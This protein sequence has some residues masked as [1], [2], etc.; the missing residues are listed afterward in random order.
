MKAG[1]LGAGLVAGFLTDL[2]VTNRWTL[3]QRH[4]G[5]RCLFGSPVQGVGNGEST[6]NLDLDQCGLSR[7]DIT[8]G[9]AVSF[10]NMLPACS[11]Q[12]RRSSLLQCGFP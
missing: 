2:A 4:S 5:P 8:F 6:M 1:V 7:A 9:S 3:A 11:T 12:D 10:S